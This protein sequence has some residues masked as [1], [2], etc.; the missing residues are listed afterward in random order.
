VTRDAVEEDPE[1]DP[2]RPGPDTDFRPGD[3]D[4]EGDIPSVVD[5]NDFRIDLRGFYFHYKG[6]LTSMEL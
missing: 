5:G 1:N 4:L 2:R 3:L 6:V